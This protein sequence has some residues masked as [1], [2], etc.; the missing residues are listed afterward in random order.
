[1]KGGIKLQVCNL[2]HGHAERG[3]RAVEVGK[4]GKG[5][6]HILMVLAGLEGIDFAK[7]I[8]GDADTIDYLQFWADADQF[9]TYSGRPM[10]DCGDHVILD[11]CPTHRYDRTDA[12]AEFLA[13]RSSWPLFSPVYSPEF[14]VLELIFNHVKTT[15]KRDSYQSFGS[16]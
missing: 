7:I 9:I 16:Q 1:M 6:N 10:F 12:L 14:N 3:N 8:P 13:Q 5:T 11:N 2:T 4:A 15:A